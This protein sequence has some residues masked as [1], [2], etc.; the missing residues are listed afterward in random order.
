MD[1]LSHGCSVRSLASSRVLSKLPFC[2]FRMEYRNHN[3]FVYHNFNLRQ[4]SPWNE[5]VGSRSIHEKIW[6]SKFSSDFENME[7]RPGHG[8]PNW[9]FW[10]CIFHN[11]D[12]LQSNLSA[13]LILLFRWNQFWLISEGEKLLLQQFWWLWILIF[14]NFH[15]WNCQKAPK[16]PN[17]ELLIRSKWQLLGLLK[18]Q[19]WIHVKSEKSWN[20]HIMYSQ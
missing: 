4:V 2:L 8:Q 11:L 5:M 6:V 14:G 3:I 16:F 13:A 19:N 17:L 7:Y 9:E 10:L 12:I 1:S 20:I 18:N 15:T